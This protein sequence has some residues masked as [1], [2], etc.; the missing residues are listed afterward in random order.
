MSVTRCSLLTARAKLT[1]DKDY[2]RTLVHEFIVETDNPNDGQLVVFDQM[3]SV[4]PDPIPPLWSTYN[5]LT[6]TGGADTDIF[7]QTRDIARYIDEEDDKTKWKV[8]CTWTPPAPG[9]GG[10]PPEANPLNDPIR[11]SLEWATFTRNIEFDI[12]GAIIVNGAGDEFD[13]PIQ[14]DDYRP[15][16]VAVKNIWPLQN[17]INL[18]LTFKNVVNSDVFYGAPAGMAKVESISSGPIQE[19]N[20]ISYYA[21]TIRVQ[22]VGI[23][24]GTGGATDDWL[25]RLVNRGRHFIAADGTKQVPFQANLKAGAT[26]GSTNPE[27]YEEA[28]PRVPLEWVNL[29]STGLRKFPDYAPAEF[30][31]TA[32]QIYPALAFSGLGI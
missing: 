26:P 18:A 14:R 6:G 15:V 4:G 31:G 30:T 21:V 32:Y 1:E 28:V 20:G 10:D 8:T 12:T 22:F 2:R 23:G 7:L 9:Q 25:V 11:Y 27:D 5:F 29:T 17:I 13:P 3:E 24:T 16:L 19:R